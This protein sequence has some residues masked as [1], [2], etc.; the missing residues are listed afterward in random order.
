M[1]RRSQI[2][3]NYANN[4]KKDQLDLFCKEA[5]RVV[6]LYIDLL[7]EQDDFN[8]KF[9]KVKVDTWLSARMQQCLGKQAFEI[10]KSQRKRKKKTKPV[11]KRH[12][13]NLD[14][15]FVT[16]I[17]DIN[18]FD[19]WI[20]IGSI[21]NR[22]KIIL[23]GKKHKH[24]NKFADWNLKKSIRLRCVNGKYYVDVY[25]EKDPE[26]KKIFGREVGLDTGYKKLIATSDY[27]TYGHELEAVYEK[28]ARKKQGGK[29]F[30]RT[31][32][33]RDNKTNR[34]V[35]QV[36]LKRVK[37]LVVED[38]KNLKQ[39]TKGKLRKTFVNKMQ[40]WSYRDVLDKLTSLAEETGF[41]L[42]KINPAY[43]SQ[44]CSA[45]GVICKSNRQGEIYK[46]ACGL[47][48]DADVNASLNILHLGVYSPQAS[49]IKIDK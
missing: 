32:V 33:E 4:G 29:A 31:L 21:G 36:P 27:R 3:I 18:S 38:L 1:I 9:V 10:V 26:N 37:T 45:C 23:P 42:K 44:R 19:I 47:F 43:T 13:F 35:N 22:I 12:S 25:F 7:W 39:K 2:N 49:Y 34:I 6:N 11:F 14:S 8:S 46:C 24:F 5:V 28:I 20:T 16:I 40:R 15:R 48:L 17:Q 41:T 30:K